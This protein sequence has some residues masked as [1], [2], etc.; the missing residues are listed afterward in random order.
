MKLKI[1][2]NLGQ[3]RAHLE[4]DFGLQTEFQEPGV[5]HEPRDSFL[6]FAGTPAFD[7]RVELEVLERQFSALV[8]E[9]VHSAIQVLDAILVAALSA[10]RHTFATTAGST[11][12]CCRG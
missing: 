12:P 1:L 5:A 6:F 4:M 7:G 11:S 3:H 2:A 9:V 10:K 8:L